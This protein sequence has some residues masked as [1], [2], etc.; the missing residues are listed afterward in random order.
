MSKMKVDIK[1][2]PG[3]GNRYDEVHIGH[4][5][6]Y[7]PNAKTVVNN[8]GTTVNINLN[9]SINIGGQKVFS[10]LRTISK[11][12]NLTCNQKYP[13]LH[14]DDHKLSYYC[15]PNEISHVGF[16]NGYFLQM[17]G[18]PSDIALALYYIKRE[19]G[20]DMIE[21]VDYAS[22]SKHFKQSFLTIDQAIELV[23]DEIQE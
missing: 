7:A 4:V 9:I 6:N 2:D 3:T 21:S 18:S 10:L 22:T 11:K 15:L 23:K 14:C 13:N 8:Q 20:E 12:F 19:F 16:S 5:D 1:G 17:S